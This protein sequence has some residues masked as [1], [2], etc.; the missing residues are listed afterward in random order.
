[1]LF[2]YNHFGNSFDYNNAT[3]IALAAVST[4]F[5][6]L[7][8]IRSSFGGAIVI[9]NVKLSPHHWRCN[10]RLLLLKATPC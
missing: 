8:T 7:V 6:A 1:M 5:K 3:S 9:G 4:L 2:P 10:C